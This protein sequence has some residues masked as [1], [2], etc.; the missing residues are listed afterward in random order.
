MHCLQT[1]CVTYMNIVYMIWLICYS[2]CTI[3]K[4]LATVVLSSYILVKQQN[5]NQVQTN[6]V[7]CI[8]DLPSFFMHLTEICDYPYQTNMYKF[9][10]LLDIC[11]N[12]CYLTPLRR[13]L[14]QWEI[15]VLLDV[16]KIPCSWY[17]IFN[18]EILQCLSN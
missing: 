6:P 5:Q 15:K 4:Y 13:F 16:L 8:A 17:S 1:I 7:N 10:A 14:E 18:S 11:P 3:L 2:I 12:T 9:T